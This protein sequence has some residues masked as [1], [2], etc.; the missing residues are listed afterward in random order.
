[1][2]QK[3]PSPLLDKKIEELEAKFA[4]MEDLDEDMDDLDE[5]DDETAAT[6]SMP[7]SQASTTS[8]MDV[9]YTPPQVLHSPKKWVITHP[10]QF[11]M[12][13]N[14][15]TLIIFQLCVHHNQCFLANKETWVNILHS[16]CYQKSIVVW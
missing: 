1:M 11:Y 3:V 16:N 13:K 6:P 7:P 8:D 10:V 12:H 2:P 9:P 15:Q 5:D 14:I 4:D